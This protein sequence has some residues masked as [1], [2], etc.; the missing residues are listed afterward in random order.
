ME[1]PP[2]TR[3]IH[4][5]GTA[6][7]VIRGTTSACAENTAVMRMRGYDIYPYATLYSG[8]GGGLQILEALK[9]WETPEGPVEAIQTTAEGW[10]AA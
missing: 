9:M 5:G 6:R 10:E 4:I 8:S 3:R 1:L 7:R 2:R